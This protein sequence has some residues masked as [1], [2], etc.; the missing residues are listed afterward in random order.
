MIDM[1]KVLLLLV[2]IAPAV[3][4]A[5]TSGPAPI[6]PAP[7]FQISAATLTL[8]RGVVN[9]VPIVVSNPGSQPMTSLQLGLVSSRNIY[10]IGNGTVNQANVPNNGMT[11]VDLPVFVSLNTSSL[12]SVGISVSYNYYTLYSDSEIRNISFGVET[13]PSPL[14]IQTNPV[15][16]SGRIGNITLNLT[17]V[18]KTALNA[19]LLQVSLPSQ[20]AA[21]LSHQPIQVGTMEPGATAQVKERV[22]IF[23]N[24]S[25]TFPLNVSVYMY[26]GTSPVELLD[27]IPL[28]SSGVINITSSSVTVSPARPTVG[29]IFSVSLILTDIGTAGAS[30]VT[31]TPVPPSGIAAYGSSSVFVGDMEVDTQVPVTMTLRANASLKS[32]SY[33]VP[34][35]INY[36]N[37]FR[38]NIS[39]TILVPVTLGAALPSNFTKTGAYGRSGGSGF[40]LL[41]AV[42]VVLAIA[43]ALWYANRKGML[44]QWIH[45]SKSK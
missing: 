35:R 17:N 21:I 28:L 40:P 4:L 43:L 6:P 30:A 19:I 23:R 9:T 15:V 16:T 44:K 29:S 1:L 24:A 39:T 34:V 26:N 3:A 31:A 45:K 33:T 32:G 12:V 38:E 13:C 20:A 42:A 7:A 36:L 37:N 2:A 8:C 25:Q 14:S 22:F 41:P 18:G 27:T 10:V 5:T 11:T